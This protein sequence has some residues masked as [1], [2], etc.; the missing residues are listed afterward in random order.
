MLKLFS[1]FKIQDQFDGYECQKSLYSELVATNLFTFRF[2][3]SKRIFHKKI[4][5][6]YFIKA[7]VFHHVSLSWMIETKKKNNFAVDEHYGELC[8]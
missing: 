2:L 1:L 5:L 3:K 7:V 4:N 6:T 8:R